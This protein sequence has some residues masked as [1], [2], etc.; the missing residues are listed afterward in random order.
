M[1]QSHQARRVRTGAAVVLASSLLVG[2]FTVAAFG[3]HAVLDGSCQ[4]QQRKLVAQVRDQAG[5]EMAK[6]ALR[7][8]AHTSCQPNIDP[9]EHYVG[10]EYELPRHVRY[11]EVAQILRNAGWTDH[12]AGQ[13]SMKSPDGRF[14]LT[15][16]M[17]VPTGRPHALL[18]TH[19]DVPSG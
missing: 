14:D 13:N 16:S 1:V 5:P 19:D 12:R 3:I 6:L 2:A 9:D 11:A 15:F 18:Y 7:K 17:Y 8:P 4:A 10:V